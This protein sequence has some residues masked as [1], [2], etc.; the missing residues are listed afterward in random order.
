[1]NS[2]H[3]TWHPGRKEL[4]YSLRMAPRV[5][6]SIRH[7]LRGFVGLAAVAAT[8]LAAC[9]SSGQGRPVEPVSSYCPGGAKTGGGALTPA[10]G[11]KNNTRYIFRCDQPKVAYTPGTRTLADLAATVPGIGTMGLK[12]TP[13]AVAVL[14]VEQDPTVPWGTRLLAAERKD[15]EKFAADKSMGDWFILV[16]DVQVAGSLDPI[17]PTAYRWTRQ[18]VDDYVSCGIPETGRNDCS[19]TFYGAA[20]VIVLAPQGAPPH[21]K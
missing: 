7:R 16:A 8:L 21:G 10:P 9:N 17:A 1:M 18:T 20:E 13:D 3:L 12:S 4:P 6:T 2:P 15:F 11:V 5:I 19:S 14:M